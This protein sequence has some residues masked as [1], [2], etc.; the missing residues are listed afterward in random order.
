MFL[1]Q[2]KNGLKI[3][4]DYVYLNF[5]NVAMKSIDNWSK[6]RNTHEE[7]IPYQ[8]SAPSNTARAVEVATNSGSDT[9]KS[10]T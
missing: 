2:Q 7:I 6:D 9:N 10:K 3:F 5:N 8:F 4:I 1:N